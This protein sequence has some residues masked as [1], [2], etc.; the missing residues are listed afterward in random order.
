M[1]ISLQESKLEAARNFANKIWNATRFVLLNCGEELGGSKPLQWETEMAPPELA[2]RWILSR[3]NQVALDVGDALAEFRLHEAASIVYHF[4]WD[5]FCDWYIELS[6]P[7]VTSPEPGPQAIAV[8]RRL[9]YV[10]ECSLRL[11][12]PIMPFIS[13]ELWQR[14]PHSG[15]TV[16]LAEFPTANA[17]QMDGRAEEE[18]SFFI[19]LVTRL[20]NI[21][22]AF[23][24]GQSV[25]LEAK[26]A[27]S[28]EETR[29]IVAAMN[30]QISRLA[31]LSKLHIVESIST[32]R[33]SA[34]AVLN[35]AEIEVPL[36]GLIDFEK[37]RERLTRELAKLQSEQE[38]LA[39]RIANR[40]FVSRAAP[41]VVAASQQ[42]A[43]EISSQVVRLRAMIDSL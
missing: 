11:L 5:D 7:F 8:R 41:D 1:P 43:Q 13:E 24:I 38:G 33:G 32:A 10:L 36:E 15:K 40:D 25:P 12:H 2:D 19:E 30:E 34:R 35:G 20:R 37:E 6:K 16:C 4:F 23:N 17:A 31:K 3:F 28:T 22:S 42:R 9:I 21:R 27:P 39:K 29:R 14:M 18:M 26:I